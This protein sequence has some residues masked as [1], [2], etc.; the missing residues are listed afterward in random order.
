MLDF[1][2]PP[3][4]PCLPPLFMTEILFFCIITIIYTI[5]I[6]NILYILSIYHTIHK[7]GR[8]VGVVGK[9]RKSLGKKI[10]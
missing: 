1:C 8:V 2:L 10:L 3:L 7:G 5:I 9:K 6:T 4:P